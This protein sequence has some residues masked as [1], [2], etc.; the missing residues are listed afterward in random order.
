MPCSDREG[1][2]HP[3]PSSDG[4]Q[5][6]NTTVLVVEMQCEGVG[7]GGDDDDGDPVQQ[8]K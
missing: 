5:M 3:E 4:H 8:C 6:K 7:G 1:C 2:C